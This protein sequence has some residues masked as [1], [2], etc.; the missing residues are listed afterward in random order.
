MKLTLPTMP[1]YAAHGPQ[2]VLQRLIAEDVENFVFAVDKL[3][4][5]L[6]RCAGIDIGPQRKLE[7]PNIVL[8]K[9][10]P[11]ARG[12]RTGHRDVNARAFQSN[13]RRSRRPIRILGD[14]E[15]LDRASARLRTRGEH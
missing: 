4:T 11:H 7:R 8:G 15:R 9:Q 1:R 10:R 3:L 14:A 13:E 5:E 12:G 6:L 2:T